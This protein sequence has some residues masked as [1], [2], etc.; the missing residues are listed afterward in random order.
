MTRCFDPYVFTK[1][2]FLCVCKCAIRK[3]THNFTG[4]F[5]FLNLELFRFNP[6]VFGSMAQMKMYIVP[7]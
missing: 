2:L 4:S 6:I 3:S 5:L 7:R 1:V